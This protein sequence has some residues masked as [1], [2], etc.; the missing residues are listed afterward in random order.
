MRYNPEAFLRVMDESNS[1]LG[2]GCYR[3]SFAE[4]IDGMIGINAPIDLKSQVEVKKGIL[5]CGLQTRALLGQGQGPGVIWGKAS[6][7]TTGTIVPV[8]FHA[9]QVISRTIVGDALVG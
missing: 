6:G 1:T 2:G 4:E 3:P 9:Q 5:R 8:D 7:S